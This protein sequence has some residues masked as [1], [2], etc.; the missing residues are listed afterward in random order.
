MAFLSE[1]A[2]TQ[3]TGTRGRKKAKGTKIDTAHIAWRIKQGEH[4]YFHLN[5]DF[6]PYHQRPK[7]GSYVSVPK[8][9]VTWHTVEATEPQTDARMYHDGDLVLYS[10]KVEKGYV[11]SR[12]S[13]KK[14]LIEPGLIYKIIDTGEKNSKW[15]MLLPPGYKTE[16]CRRPPIQAVSLEFVRHITIATQTERHRALEQIKVSNFLHYLIK[17]RLSID[18]WR[19]KDNCKIYILHRMATEPMVLEMLGI[20]ERNPMTILNNEELRE[21]VFWRMWDND[22]LRLVQHQEQWAKM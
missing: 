1:R 21:D 3:K 4:P 14:V 5:P 13:N 11:S 17:E 16:G 8:I 6:L 20:E 12:S 22:P 15:V 18:T 7:D 10:G 2:C 19:K 9:L